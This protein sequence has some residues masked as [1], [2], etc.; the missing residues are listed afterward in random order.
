LESKCMLNVIGILDYI[1]Q[2]VKY[3]RL[4]ILRN[5]VVYTIRSKTSPGRTL[6]IIPGR[7]GIKLR[8]C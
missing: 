5:Y 3:L 7:T 8:N 2:N 1:F 4:K 6:S